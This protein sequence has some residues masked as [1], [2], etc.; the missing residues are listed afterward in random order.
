MPTQHPLS[1]HRGQRAATSSAR[2]ICEWCS[3]GGNPSF[4]G[5]EPSGPVPTLPQTTLRPERYALESRASSSV[6]SASGSNCI[7]FYRV[8]LHEN[9]SRPI[10]MT[11]GQASEANHVHSYR[12]VVDFHKGG[13]NN[14]QV[15][16]SF[17]RHRDL[18]IELRRLRSP[19]Y[20]TWHTPFQW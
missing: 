7:R 13:A 20:V 8:R 9:G 16:F 3:S 1:A 17:S 10:R 6:S 19:A 14:F 2:W 4:R 5:H 12:L 18:S 11:V 15:L